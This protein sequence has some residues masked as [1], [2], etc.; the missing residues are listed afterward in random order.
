MKS[1]SSPGG[2][3][4]SSTVPSVASCSLGST[5]RTCCVKTSV[6]PYGMIYTIKVTLALA[7]FLIAIFLTSS[8]PKWASFQANRKKSAFGRAWRWRQSS[9][10]YL[11]FCE[12]S[13]RLYD[14][15]DPFRLEGAMKIRIEYCAK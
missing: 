12:C 6:A 15:G 1:L 2:C 14:G 7:V 11:P 5:T 10:P 3:A 4:S 13:R 9:S 8:R